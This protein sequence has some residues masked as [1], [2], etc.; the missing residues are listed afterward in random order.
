MILTNV[1]WQIAEQHSLMILDQFECFFEG[2]LDADAN[3][4]CVCCVLM[5]FF[6]V[7]TFM[8]DFMTQFLL[9][10]W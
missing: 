3:N 2:L 9:I 10:D 7:Q 8:A 1:I 4:S 6:E 5:Y